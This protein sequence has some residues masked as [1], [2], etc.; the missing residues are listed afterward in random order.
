MPMIGN[1]WPVLGIGRDTLDIPASEEQE[2]GASWHLM[3]STR[4]L[5]MTLPLY[6][7]WNPDPDNRFWSLTDSPGYSGSPAEE[8]TTLGRN[9]LTQHLWARKCSYSWK[10]RK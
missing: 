4:C 10:L 8:L 2:Y 3:S 7:Q 9:T 1:D 6:W 5:M